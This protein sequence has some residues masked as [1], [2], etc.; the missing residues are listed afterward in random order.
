M[1]KRAIFVYLI[2]ASM[3][4]LS[5]V[6]FVRADATEPTGPTSITR[7]DNQRMNTSYWGSKTI[8]AMA[9][10]L[11]EL[12]ITATTQT[13]TWQGYYGNITGTITLDDASNFTMYS[14]EELEPQGEIY[15]SN[16]T[17]VNWTGIKCFNYSSNISDGF[18]NGNDL[19]NLTDLENMYGLLNDDNDGV[20]ETFNMTGNISSESLSQQ[21]KR[22]WVGT[23]FIGQG[24]C[25]AT[26]MYQ[27]DSNLGFDFQEILLSDKKAIVFT[28]LIEND[29]NGSIDDISGFNNKTYDFQMLVGENG[30]DGD[31]AITNYYF[32]VELE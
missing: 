18:E 9:G 12:K 2:L 24:K 29:I 16:A 11:T 19:Y 20:D 3:L 22:L 21:H 14:W 7:Q 1:K 28:T 5:F 26:H 30:H 25:P 4:A 32:F 10:N 15:A 8:Q 23:V 13:Q 6:S 31:L 27:N 17:T